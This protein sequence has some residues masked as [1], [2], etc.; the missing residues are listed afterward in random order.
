MAEF[1]VVCEALA[2]AI[3]ARF[4]EVILEGDNLAV[5]SAIQVGEDGV[6]FGGVC[7]ADIGRLRLPCTWL[8]I[9]FMKREGNFVAHEFARH[10]RSLSDFYV[11]LEE[12]PDWVVETLYQDSN[13]IN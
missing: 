12:Q 8:D 5:I 10:A 9:A 11:W 2:F 7:V 6:S 13:D 3:D 1:V 4:R